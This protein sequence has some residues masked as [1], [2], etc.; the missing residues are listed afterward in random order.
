MSEI[1]HVPVD[2]ANLRWFRQESDE[3][4]VWWDAF[5]GDYRPGYIEY[6]DGSYQTHLN[7]TRRGSRLAKYRPGGAH[8]ALEEAKA[9]VERHRIKRLKKK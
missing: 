5:V 2:P 1:H 9:E 6:G 3:G 8:L 7:V 4:H